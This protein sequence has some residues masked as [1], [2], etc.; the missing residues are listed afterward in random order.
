[1]HDKRHLPLSVLP[2]GEGAYVEKRIFHVGGG[3]RRCL[4]ESQTTRIV[5]L[6]ERVRG[7]RRTRAALI[8]FEA[9]ESRKEGR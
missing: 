9:W 7:D 2:N 6:R 1:M 5:G 3:A 4:Y 8:G